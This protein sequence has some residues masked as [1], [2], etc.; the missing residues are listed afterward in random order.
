MLTGDDLDEMGRLKYYL[1][2]ELEIKGLGN[3]KYFLGIEVARSKD[4]IFLS[5]R[6]YVLDLLK[7]TGMLG[8]KAVD[9]PMDHTLKLSDNAGGE[10]VE[11]GSSVIL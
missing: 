11:K 4:G 3:L 10:L 9:T 8:C 5:Q 1:A 7:E 6:W 2:K